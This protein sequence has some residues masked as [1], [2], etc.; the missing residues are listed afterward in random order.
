MSTS[1]ARNDESTTERRLSGA[2][3]MLADWSQ[4]PSGVSIEAVVGDGRRGVRR[5]RRAAALGVAAVFA[6]SA[7]GVWGAVEH[8]PA[9][10][11]A[12]AGPDLWGHA[13]RGKDPMVPLASFGWLPGPSTGGFTWTLTK[14][15]DF[16][17]ADENG[18]VNVSL[19]LQAVGKPEPGGTHTPAGTVDGRPAVLVSGMSD[20]ELL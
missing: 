10:T 7:I 15:G 6:A 5:R 1:D 14:G 19:T 17:I 11:T 12:S 16:N 20:P 9:P 4:P 2:P 13:L 18:T 3:A 8:L